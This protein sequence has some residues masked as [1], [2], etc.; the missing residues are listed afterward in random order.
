MFMKRRLFLSLWIVLFYFF[1]PGELRSTSLCETVGTEI[2]CT[3]NWFLLSGSASMRAVERTR[4]RGREVILWRGKVDRPGGVLG[5]VVSLLKA[6]KGA[7]VFDS[8]ID[9]ETHLPIECIEYRISSEGVKE[10]LEHILYDRKNCSIRSLVK[11]SVLTGV[12]CDVQDG[13]STLV[14]FLNGANIHKMAVGK[15]LRANMNAGMEIDEVAV[16]VTVIETTENGVLYTFTSRKLPNLLKYPTV[17]SV[18]LLDDGVKKV[19]IN[20]VGFVRVPVIGKV[21]LK[22]TLTTS[23]I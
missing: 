12:P 7:T 6:Y 17:L 9:I 5:F 19:P 11:D 20:G 21:K 13:V 23:G 10:I 4:L 14:Y 18:Q 8:Y 16:G 1:I 22:G 2:I 3:A 15:I